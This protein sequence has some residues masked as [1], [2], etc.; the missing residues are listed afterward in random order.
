MGYDVIFVQ[1]V[2]VVS[3]GQ[4]EDFEGRRVDRVPKGGQRSFNVI[5]RG[6]EVG[7]F[8]VYD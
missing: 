4:T 3:G 2:L 1:P 8:S 5:R 7:E 6:G